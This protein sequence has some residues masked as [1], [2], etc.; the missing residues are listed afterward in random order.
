MSNDQLIQKLLDDHRQ[1]V[2]DALEKHHE[3]EEWEANEAAEY[4]NQG[5]A[6]PQSVHNY[7]DM[8]M[9]RL[10]EVIRAM[11]NLPSE[12]VKS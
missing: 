10:T 6:I 12:G 4:I 11:N 7:T 5:E 2:T 1:F 3:R 9:S 8:F